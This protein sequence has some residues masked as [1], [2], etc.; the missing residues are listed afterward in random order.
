[1]NIISKAGTFE[2][3]ENW[4]IIPDNET[5]RDN[6]RTHGVVVAANG[7]VLVFHQAVPAV[8]VYDG[9]G[10]LLDSWGEFPGAHGMTLL[11]ENGREVLW[12]TDEKTKRVVKT[13]LGGEE[14]LS[15]E[16]PPHAVYENGE[17]P[18]IPTWATQDVAGSGDIWVADGY[19]AHLVH[20]FDSAGNYKSTLTGEEGAGRFNC[21]HG[22]DIDTRRPQ[23]ELY[24]A[25]R[26][27]QRI[28]VY[29]LDG[30]FQREFGSNFFT[31]PDVSVTWRDQLVVPELHARL[32]ILDANDQLIDSI[33]VNDTVAKAEG[34]PNNRG[35]VEESKFNSPHGAAADAD[36]NFYVVEWITG[37]RIIKLARR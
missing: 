16:Q 23:H 31:S 34:W 8:L 2:W 27:N 12:L 20:R 22:I 13:T 7:N 18:Y 11:E 19:G 25:D 30:E 4:A 9:S 3:I 24:V 6:G 29:N 35:N 1:M 32:T 37:G 28:Q 36:G 5:S 26:G 17:K 10:N 33:G 21:P 14:L 15:L